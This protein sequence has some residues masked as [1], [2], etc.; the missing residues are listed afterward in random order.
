MFLTGKLLI[1]PLMLARPGPMRLHMLLVQLELR[2]V[3]LIQ[4]LDREMQILRSKHRT[5]SVEK[6]SRTTTRISFIVSECGSHGVRRDDPPALAEL[7]RDGEL[8]EFVPVL[9]V[10]AEGDEGEP[11]AAA[12]RQDDEAHLLDGGGRGSRRCG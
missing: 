6:S 2:L 4:L 8:V 10:Q 5:C 11:L 12:L 9:G 7:V 3:H 1:H